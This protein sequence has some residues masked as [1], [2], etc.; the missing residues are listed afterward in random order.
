MGRPMP[1]K[2]EFWTVPFEGD[3]LAP[4]MEAAGQLLSTSLGHSA[5]VISSEMVGDRW[6]PKRGGSQMSGRFDYS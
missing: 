3:D 6:D 4:Y 1:I 2:P 5:T